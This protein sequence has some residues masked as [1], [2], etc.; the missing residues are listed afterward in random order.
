MNEI[1]IILILTFSN[2]G[3][4]K[5]LIFI[6]VSAENVNGSKYILFSFI[7]I[8]LQKWKVAFGPFFGRFPQ[9]FLKYDEMK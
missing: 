2:I 1:K 8:K 3:H 4:N 7:K 9:N 6:N 5:S